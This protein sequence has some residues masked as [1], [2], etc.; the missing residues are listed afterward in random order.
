MSEAI[1]HEPT[2]AILKPRFGFS[3]Y[4]IHR[5]EMRFEGIDLL[6]GAIRPRL[7]SD[8]RRLAYAKNGLSRHQANHARTR[9]PGAPK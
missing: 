3:A 7:A 4:P 9:W 5:L 2:F 1:G 6:D 8:H